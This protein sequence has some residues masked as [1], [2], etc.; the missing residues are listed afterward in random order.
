MG[1]LVGAMV[2]LAAGALSGGVGWVLCPLLGGIA[3]HLLF[4][5][6]AGFTD[7]DDPALHDRGAS[8]AEIDD[9]ARREFA[10]RLVPLFVRV[11]TERGAITGE[12]VRAIRGFFAEGLGFTAA[13]LESVRA[14]I[15]A[16]RAEPADLAVLLHAA[17]ENLDPA[18]RSLLLYALCRLATDLDSPLLRAICAGLDLDPAVVAAMRA[19]APPRSAPRP[20]PRPE[21]EPDGAPD[22]PLGDD[23][24]A[25]LGLTE[26][27]T[28][29]EVKQA[30]RALAQKLHPDKVGHLGPEAVAL[31]ARAFGQVSEAY[32]RIRRARGL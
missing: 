10:R 28:D 1:K 15:Q 4:D 3:G 6:R 7:P 18:E 11:A 12:Q 5:A 21:A 23:P 25:H 31:S 2:G 26:R 20:E 8:S 17:R 13:E 16:A 29:A 30:F 14:A 27:A 24:Y 9:A 32:E 22:A 19:E